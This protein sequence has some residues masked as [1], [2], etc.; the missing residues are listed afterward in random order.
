MTMTACPGVAVAVAVTV[1]VL[2]SV[3]P[4]STG[5]LN[6]TVTPL[7]VKESVSVNAAV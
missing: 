4:L 5:G 6:D 3:L 7:G 1:R 2:E